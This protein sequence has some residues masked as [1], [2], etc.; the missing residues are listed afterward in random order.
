MSQ[1]DMRIPSLVEPMISTSAV[2]EAPIEKVWRALT[3]P[4]RIKKWF[5]GV[6]T[7]TD[8]QVGGPIVHR[9]EYQGKAYEDK[10]TVEAFARPVLLAYT[11][12]SSVSGKPDSPESYQTVTFRLVRQDSVTKLTVTEPAG[13]RPSSCRCRWHRTGRYPGPERPAGRRC[14]RWRGRRVRE[15]LH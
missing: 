8:W 2:I 14:R 7:L 13:H 5:F 12:W 10:G 11:H 6:D 15:P 3:D 4:A 1:G 9:G